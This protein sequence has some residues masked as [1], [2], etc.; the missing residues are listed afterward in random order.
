MNLIGNVRARLDY[1]LIAL[2]DPTRR[3]ILEALSRRDTRVT[4]AAAP[5]SI[6]LNAV[7]K[8]IRLL[9]RA[10]L[11]RRRVHGPR[12]HS[13]ARSPATGSGRSVDRD[14][15]DAMACDIDA[16]VGGVFT[17][18]DRRYGED[19]V[20]TGDLAERWTRIAT[21]VREAAAFMAA[22]R[23]LPMADHD[24]RACGGTS[25]CVRKVRH[26]AV[27]PTCAAA[28]RRSTERAD[29]GVDE[30]SDASPLDSGLPPRARGS[31]SDQ[32]RGS[33]QLGRQ[34]RCQGNR[35]RFD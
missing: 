19:V 25:A 22:Q 18:T 1:T 2:A 20:H 33:G 34:R 15:P 26:G 24:E 21:Q 9:E 7:S 30:G 28:G 27:T 6:S 35:F 14:A 16:R 17:I 32:L 11:V 13:V 23:D 3:A 12:A 10:G 8:H 31:V 29:V 4:D 5:F